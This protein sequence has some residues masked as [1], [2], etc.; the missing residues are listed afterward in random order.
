MGILSKIFKSDDKVD[1]KPKATTVT[2]GTKVAAGQTADK[3]AAV[4][5]K[6]K[7]DPNAFRYLST[8]L[9]TEKATDLAM[10]NKYCFI[11]PKSANKTEVGKAVMNIY[12]ARPIKIN[13]VQRPGKAVRHGKI[14]GLTKAYK[15]AIITLKAGQKIEL[16][17]GV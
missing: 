1:Q 5:L 13:F 15:K 14:S 9:I 7:A 4:P 2:A 12:G 11:V 17:E 3:P 10:F 16:Y 6:V 8:P